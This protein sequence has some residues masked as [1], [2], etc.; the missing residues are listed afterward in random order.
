M[1]FRIYI[2]KKTYFLKEKRTIKKLV[3][4]WM[5]RNLLRKIFDPFERVIITSFALMISFKIFYESFLFSF[6]VTIHFLKVT[7]HFL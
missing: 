1:L 6:F 5:I 3:Y 2:R 7:F 4:K